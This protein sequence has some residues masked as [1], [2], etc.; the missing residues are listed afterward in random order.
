ME[1]QV[2]AG[3]REAGI[4]PQIIYADK[5]TGRLGIPGLMDNWSADWRAEWEAAVDDYFAPEDQAKATRD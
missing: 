5:K 2:V 1:D 4:G 3:M